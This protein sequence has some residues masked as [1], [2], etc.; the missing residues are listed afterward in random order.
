M[1]ER[2]VGVI[3]LLAAAQA[4]TAVYTVGA[5]GSHASPQAAVDAAFSNPGPDEVR[6]RDGTLNATLLIAGNLAGNELIVSGGWDAAYA[7]NAGRSSTLDAGGSAAVLRASLTGGSLQLFRLRLQGGAAA[8][9]PA[10]LSLAVSGFAA[11]V[12]GELE[13]A[14]GAVADGSTGC[15][16]LD[17]RDDGQLYV[18]D[19]SVHD[20]SNGSIAVGSAK[21]AGL[22][23]LAQDR[24]QVVID[25]LAAHHNLS[26]ATVQAEG[27]GINLSAS[28]Q[29]AI[30]VRASRIH[31]NTASAPVAFGSGLA[32][33]LDGSASAT[34]SRLQI[35]DNLAPLAAMSTAQAGLAASASSQLRMHSSLLRDGPQ[36]GLTASTSGSAARVYLHNLGI[37]QHAERGLAF[38]GPAGG[39]TLHNSIVQDNGFP[40]TLAA[41]AGDH[42]LGDDLG[43]ANAVFA[44][45]GDFRL[46]AGSP[47]IDAGTASLPLGLAASDLDGE[48]RIQGLTVDIGPY[49]LAPPL[50]ISGFE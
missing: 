36:R 31:A 7:S 34:L 32:V 4:S 50:F 44:G 35:H 6:L 42:N 5:G 19:T 46:V 13:V 1:I 30:V 10:G 41:S 33:S 23:V 11:V 39:Q 38:F 3:G 43:Q 24:A 45:A 2:V 9:Q 47:G 37:V 20:C 8:S 29:A 21:A 25:A 16:G 12:A 40:T 15:I 14:D 17:A 28:H 18:F 22:Q 26:R 27:S 48:A 49:E